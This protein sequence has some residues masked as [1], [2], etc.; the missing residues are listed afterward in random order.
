MSRFWKAN[1]SKDYAN[2]DYKSVLSEFSGDEIKRMLER[3]SHIHI[4]E[5]GEEIERLISVSEK[6]LLCSIMYSTILSIKFCDITTYA[7]I[8]AGE[9][10]ADCLFKDILNTDLQGYLSYFIPMWEFLDFLAFKGKEFEIVDGVLLQYHGNEKN[11]V[12]PVGV[13]EI[14]KE[15]FE[16]NDWIYSVSIPDSV[17]VIDKG[18]FRACHNLKNIS[19]PDSVTSIGRGA[20]ENCTSLESVFIPDSVTEIGDWAF[21]GCPFQP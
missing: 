8:S 18:A 15:A 21:E 7:A 4:K 16:F 3:I 2:R 1:L 14:G 20:F 5:N 6:N 12:I 11:V 19:I 9:Y 13:T 10:T 17:L